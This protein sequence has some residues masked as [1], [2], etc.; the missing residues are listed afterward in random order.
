MEDLDQDQKECVH[1]QI[2]Q[3][4]SMTVYRSDVVRGDL[5]MEPGGF[6]PPCRNGDEA[7][8]TCVVTLFVLELRCG[9]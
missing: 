6:E 9:W 4:P 3:V 8:S 2:L 7:A 5:P 1:F